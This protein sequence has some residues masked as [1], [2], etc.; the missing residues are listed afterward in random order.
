MSRTPEE[1]DLVEKCI[2]QN[3]HAQKIL[4]DKYF[5]KMMAI[6]LRYLKSEDDAAEALSNAFLKVFAKIKQY[7]S[8]GSL[9]GW[10]KK[11]VINS[12]IDFVRSNKAYRDKF[13]PTEEFSSYDST[14]ESDSS[15]DSLPDAGS[16]LSTEQIFELVKELPNATRIVFNL[17]VIDEF[18]HKQIA[19][20]IGISEGASRWHLSNAKKLLREKINQ[21]K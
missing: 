9:E 20:N 12:A 1:N 7:K 13:V 3:H 8:E 19:E 18:A 16:H 5:N 6:C 10:I 21:T 2:K 11:I 15:P 14:E 4:Y 17:Y